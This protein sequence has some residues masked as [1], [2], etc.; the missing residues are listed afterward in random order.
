MNKILS[1]VPLD[2]YSIF[3]NSGDT[4]KTEIKNIKSDYDFFLVDTYKENY[5][6]KNR[7]KIKLHT[8]TECLS[9]QSLIFRKKS[10]MYFDEII[11]FVVTTNSP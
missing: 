6:K 1:L 9:H 2:V 8:M 10:G 3:L 4:I 5:K 7:I 11:K